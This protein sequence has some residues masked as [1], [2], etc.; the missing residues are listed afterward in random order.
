[1][2]QEFN[3]SR[4]GFVDSQNSSLAWS[5]SDALSRMLADFYEISASDSLVQPA[6]FKNTE[7]DAVDTRSGNQNYDVSS[8]IQSSTITGVYV[9]ITGDN[10]LILKVT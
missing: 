5:R 10:Y 6:S 8:R 4:R 3:Q 7:Q 9:T 1:M 2:T